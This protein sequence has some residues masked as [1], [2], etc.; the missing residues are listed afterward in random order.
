MIRYALACENAHEFDGWFRNSDDFDA[1]SAQ[2]FVVCPVCGTQSVNKT[3]MAP[4]VATARKKAA[5]DVVETDQKETRQ[6]TAMLQPESLSQSAEYQQVLEKLRV[7]RRDVV[8]S[9]EYVGSGFAE[10]AR[11]IHY[12][13]TEERNIYGET[14][15]ADAKELLDEGV[16]VLPLPMLPDDQN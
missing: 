3:L 11:K 15:V 10:E 4:S 8:N 9:S 7:F 6:K 1:Q 16:S 2:G 13:E 12:G 5:R 14:S